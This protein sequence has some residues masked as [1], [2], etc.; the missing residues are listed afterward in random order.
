MAFVAA[1]LR[2]IDGPQGRAIYRYDTADALTAVEVP[3]YINNVDDD[4]NIAKGDIFHVVVWSTA[5]F[6]GLPTDYGIHVCV[7]VA[8]NDVNLSTDQLGGTFTS[9]A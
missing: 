8:D 1:N 5:V 7:D 4:Q 2:L 6:T 3:G 9:T